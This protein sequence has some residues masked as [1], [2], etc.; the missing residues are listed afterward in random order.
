MKI[1]W[2]LNFLLGLTLLILPLFSLSMTLDHYEFPKF[3]VLMLFSSGIFAFLVSAL[4]TVKKLRIRIEPALVAFG[5]LLLFYLVAI[6]KSVNPVISILGMYPHTED[7]LLSLVC[8]LSL[9]LAGFLVFSRYKFSVFK[10]LLTYPA[11]GAIISLAVGSYQFLKSYLLSGSS[12]VRVPG[13]EE[14]PIYFATF[15]AFS[16]YLFLTLRVLSTGKERVMWTILTGYSLLAVVLTFTRSV[17]LSLSFSLIFYGFLYFKMTSK[18][19]FKAKTVFCII[20]VLISLFFLFGNSLN[21]RIKE[22]FEKDQRKNNLFIRIWE[23]ESA[24]NAFRQSP[25]FGYGPATTELIIPKFRKLELNQT[26]EW[27]RV[28]DYVRNQF[29]NLLVTTGLL[30]AI[31]YFA[32]ITLVFRG[33]LKQLQ[34]TTLNI[35][36]LVVVSL[37]SGWVF[38]VVQQLFYHLTVTSSSLF[39]TTS[40]FLVAWTYKQNPSK[41]I[42]VKWSRGLSVPILFLSLFLAMVAVLLLG[43]DLN[44]LKGLKI[45][46]TITGEPDKRATFAFFSNQFSE[47][48]LRKTNDSLS[49]FQKALA[50]NPYNE[51]YRRQYTYALLTKAKILSLKENTKEAKDYYNQAIEESHLTVKLSPESYLNNYFLA[52]S[53]MQASRAVPEDKELAIAAMRKALSVNPSDPAAWDNLGL[54]YLENKNLTQAEASFKKEIELKDDLADSYLHLGETLKQEGKFNEA[55]KSYEGVFKFS[56]ND[57]L[58]TEEINKVQ[59]IKSKNI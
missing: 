41:E 24:L 45:F 17:W 51:V 4:L 44:F 9:F 11:V 22:S 15:I 37:F 3:I 53:Y 57:P 1:P 14:H 8:S 26:A 18:I 5:V 36:K 34:R 50:L 47:T 42:E 38:L 16:V 58:T 35:D 2:Y 20:L 56:P 10:N 49:Y 28:T 23:I 40:G 29:V 43:S 27:Y 32:F 46:N 52:I 25:I 54:F 30:G 13:L 33:I 12:Y 7:G 59:N 39:W 48:D 55:I 21:I 19:L 6:L 31:S